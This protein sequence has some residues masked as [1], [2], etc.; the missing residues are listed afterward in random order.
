MRVG[1]TALALASVVSLWATAA[2]GQTVLTLADVLTKAREQA[3]RVLA[4]RLAVEEARGRLAGASLRQQSN[5]EIDL[6]VGNRQGDGAR[7]TDFQV[8]AT[9][10]FEPPGRR[11]ARA[12]DQEASDALRRRVRALEQRARRRT[13]R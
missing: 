10:M 6:S 4:A 5:P 8:G 9:Q 13:G 3:P 1:C 11:S 2:K 12:Y 7:W